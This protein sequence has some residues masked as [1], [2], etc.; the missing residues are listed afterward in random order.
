VSTDHLLLEAA[1]GVTIFDELCR[2]LRC[3]LVNNPESKNLKIKTLGC[4]T[5]FPVLVNKISNSLSTNESD[6]LMGI[7]EQAFGIEWGSRDDINKNHKQLA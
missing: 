6:L 2:V 5:L 7:L 3:T 1:P 4:Y